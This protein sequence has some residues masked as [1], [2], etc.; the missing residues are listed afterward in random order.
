METVRRIKTY[1]KQFILTMLLVSSKITYA[2]W[3]TA[4]FVSCIWIDSI[5]VSGIPTSENITLGIQKIRF[6]HEM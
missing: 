2:P 5:Q 1:G 4:G 3:Q 6:N